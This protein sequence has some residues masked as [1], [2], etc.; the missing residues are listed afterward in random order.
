MVPVGVSS[1]ELIR[2]A[3]NSLRDQFERIDSI[4]F[5]NQ[6]RVLEAFRSNRLSET[7]FAEYTGYAIDDAGREVLD[8]IFADCMFAELAAVRVQL[9][10]GTHALACALFGN[11]RPGDRL[12]I[13][14]GAPYDTLTKVI[15]QA[16]PHSG[17]LKELKVDYLE[18]DLFADNIDHKKRAEELS[19][20]L[21]SPTK[22]AYIQK[23]CGYSFIRRSISNN[24]I[25]ELCKEIRKLNPEV[26]ILVDNCYGEF[27]EER[28]PPDCG[29]DLIA[30]SLIKNPGGGLAVSGGYLAGKAQLVE[31]ALDRLTAPGI[32]G[33]QGAL[34]NQGR[35]LFQ[36]L[37]F[38][39]SVVAN[40]VK[41]AVLVAQ[42]FTELGLNVKPSP[43]EERYDIIQALE[44]KNKEALIRFCRIVQAASPVNAHVVPEP[45]EMPGYEDKV[46]MAGGTFVE[47]STIELSADGPIRDPYVAYFQGGLSYIHTKVMIEQV[48]DGVRENTG[49]SKNIC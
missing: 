21:A 1:R 37:F 29:A 28:E 36:G 6:K 5:V 11:L 17:S 24:Q 31:A 38:A 12:A 2:S 4:A 26:K 47:G 27:V 34:F 49:T 45:A 18:T 9:V 20:A 22:V 25:A 46:I 39:P 33:R 16:S 40:A 35:L 42:V 41:G 10:S 8:R 43:K 7:H 15:G 44:L 13:L 14:T 32:G 23:S 30:G 48:V 3:E 19:R